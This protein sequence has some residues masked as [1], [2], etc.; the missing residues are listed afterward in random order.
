MAD[1]PEPNPP[2]WWTQNAPPMPA[3][4]TPNPTGGGWGGYPTPTG[5]APSTVAQPGSTASWQGGGWDNPRGTAAGLQKA[6]ER[7]LTGQAAV[8]WANANGYPG[9]AYYPDKNTYGLPDGQYVAPNPTNANTFD[10]IQRQAGDTGGG[11]GPAPNSSAPLPVTDYGGLGSTP[12]PYVN[13]TWT[14]GPAP[15]APALTQ[16]TAPTLAELKASPGYQARLDAGLYGENSSAAAKGSVLSGGAQQELAQYGQNF[17]SN[18]YSN[19]FGQKL[20]GT[21]ANNATTQAGFGNAFQSYMANYGQF[22]DAA[23]RGLGAYNT[24][25]ATQRNAGNDYWSH[26]AH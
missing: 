15:T 18:E 19:L 11:S 26:H 16:F 22:T 6:F 21:Q 1:Q 12:S 9:I 20:A 5:Q 3:D 14:G 25:V 24:N 13:P 2:D 8:D 4:A 10:L 17:A 23:A 7:G